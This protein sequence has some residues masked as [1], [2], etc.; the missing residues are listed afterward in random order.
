MSKRLFE[1]EKPARMA[2]FCHGNEINLFCYKCEVGQADRGEQIALRTRIQQQKA[3]DV[4]VIAYVPAKIARIDENAADSN[5]IAGNFNKRG[6]IFSKECNCDKAC[7][8][9]YLV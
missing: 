7:A 6:M 1:H 5:Y 3:L 4:A 9:I 2:G 8:I